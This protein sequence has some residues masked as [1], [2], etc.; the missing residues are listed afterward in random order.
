MLL[1]V[2]SPSTAPRRTGS[3]AL[4]L[5]TAAGFIAASLI[6]VARPAAA[7]QPQQGCIPE[8]LAG[9]PTKGPALLTVGA[10]ANTPPPPGGIKPF[11]FAVT[12]VNAIPGRTV[13]V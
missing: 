5:T 9:T 4:I 10:Y 1:E 12:L 7:Q 8:V 13:Q 11:F 2:H 6:A 3:R